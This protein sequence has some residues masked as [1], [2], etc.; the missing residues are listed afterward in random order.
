ME[1]EG[2]I[3]DLPKDE[4]ILVSRLRALL[5]DTEPRFREK[6]SYGV[7]YFS[8]RRRVCFIWPAS[9][10]LGP[11]NA[12]VSFGF[13]YGNLLSNEQGVLLSEG[14]K[15]VHIVRFSSMRD[16]NEKELLEIIREALIIDELF[17]PK[18]KS[19]KI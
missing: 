17:L 14:R 7:P 18:K 2:F 11:I 12:K 10:P 19:K 3:D 1:L 13:C 4:R 9:A 16:I 6:L 15:Q 5:F 8:L